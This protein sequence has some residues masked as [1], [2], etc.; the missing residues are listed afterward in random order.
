MILAYG[1][2][3]LGK[4]KAA[5]AAQAMLGLSSEF[6]LKKTTDKQAVRVASMSTLGFLID[7]P[8]SPSEFSEKVLI[9][10]GKGALTS[11][12]S[13]YKPRCS[14]IA[15]LN[16]ECLEDFA[17]LPK[18]YVSY[19]AALQYFSKLFFMHAGILLEQ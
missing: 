11:C 9:H 2:V 5:E 16:N 17:S 7:D 8:S 4:S 14:F 12:T 18:R 1:N 10:F 3:N 6:T 15:T 13:S 19:L